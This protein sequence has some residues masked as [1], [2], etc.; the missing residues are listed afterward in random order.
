MNSITALERWRHSSS[1]ACSKANRVAVK[2]TKD[3]L[4]FWDWTSLL[5][6]I[7]HLVLS[8]EK[9]TPQW[10]FSGP[11]SSAGSFFCRRFLLSCSFV[12]LLSLG[13][14]KGGDWFMFVSLA[15]T[16]GC[17][18]PWSR[19]GSL[20]MHCC[21]RRGLQRQHY[22]ELN[23]FSYVPQVTFSHYL[24]CLLSTDLPEHKHCR[25]S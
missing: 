21:H 23:L 20:C 9:F 17:P 6:L 19:R 3:Q 5:T 2:G 8:V 11:Q 22:L 18:R 16:T 12:C 1:E 10:D 4:F 14:P 13:Y 7:P 25:R 24:Q 15:E